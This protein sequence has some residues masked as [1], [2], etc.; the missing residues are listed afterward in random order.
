MMATRKLNR[1]QTDYL[2][3]GSAGFALG[4]ALAFFLFAM[5]AHMFEALVSATGLPTI[6]PAAEAPLGMTARI[7]AASIAGL[8]VGIAVVMAFL[9]TGRPSEKKRGTAQWTQPISVQTDLIFPDPMPTAEEAAPIRPPAVTFE[10]LTAPETP[11]APVEQPVKDEPIFLDFHAFR[12][13][14]RPANDAPPL[15]LGQ[16]KV[17]EPSE[18][19]PRAAEARPIHAPATIADDEPISVL[20]QRLEAGLER[21]SEQGAAPAQ[22]PKIDPS[23]AG[24]RSTLEE[25]RKMA[26]RR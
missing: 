23:G 5:P 20:M 22:P 12:A 2:L 19:V 10:V 9:I 18:P 1:R 21:R 11:V 13:A 8:G 14:G 4:L 3:A 26:V 15:D 17:I 24:L 6:L 25:L 7:V 16:W